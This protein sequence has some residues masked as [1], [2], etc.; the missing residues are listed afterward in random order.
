MKRN[1]YNLRYSNLCI[2]A[3]MLFFATTAAAQN[4]RTLIRQGNRAY[5]AQKWVQ[6]E[7]AYRKAL[8]KN[9]NNPQAVYNLGCALMEQ[10]KDSAAIS[11]LNQAGQM[12]KSKIRKAMC[13]HNLG[14]IMQTHQQYGQAIEAYKQALRN[15]PADNET[16]Y[17]LALCKKLLKN[18]PQKNNQNNK[19]NK[20][21]NKDKNKNKDKQKQNKDKRNKNQ[22]QQKPNPQKNEMSKDN[23]EQLLN[24]A[25][26]QEKA[27][28]Q[29]LR[30]AMGAPRSKTLQKNW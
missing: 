16:R 18:N 25:I 23:A 11:Y 26:Q 20:D 15:N 24:S 8:S 28:K 4:D 30:K 5:R 19:N 27:T 29:K 13:Y 10:R 7:T 21:K 17:N 6:A 1:I 9:R 2:L 12:E 14:V 3:V 22:N